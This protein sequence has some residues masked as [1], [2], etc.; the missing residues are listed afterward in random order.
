VKGKWDAQFGPVIRKLANLEQIQQVTETS[1]PAAGFVVKGIEFF[2]PLAGKLDADEEKEKLQKELEYTRGFLLSV[3]KKLSNE[4][5][6]AAAPEQVITS[7][8]NKQ[9]DAESKIKALEE[10]LAS[11][12]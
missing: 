12:V 3:Q 7:E 9:A 1:G 10:Q 5:F 8:R 6:V 4:R 11:L 2:V